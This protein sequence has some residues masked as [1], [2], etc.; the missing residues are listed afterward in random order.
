M[1]ARLR[2]CMHT[3]KEYCRIQFRLATGSASSALRILPPRTFPPQAQ[4]Q[5]ISERTPRALAIVLAIDQ[6]QR[7]ALSLHQHLWF[8][9]RIA[10]FS[11]LDAPE[12]CGTR[13]TAKKQEQ[14]AASELCSPRFVSRVV[15]SKFPTTLR[16]IRPA[17]SV[18]GAT[19]LVLSTRNA[20]G[21]SLTLLRGY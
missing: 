20:R 13:A 8:A 16:A 3:S 12:A 4:S 15:R 11:P 5:R 19:P 10:R 9:S 7:A 17:G 21:G 1:A 2:F 18:R 14:D 6:Q